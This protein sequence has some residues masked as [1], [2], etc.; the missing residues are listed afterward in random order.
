[1]I[2]QDIE[3][4]ITGPEI[5]E[6]EIKAIWDEQSGAEITTKN[7]SS[8]KVD[9]P[10]GF[11]GMGIRLCPDELLLSSAG[12]CLLLTFLHLAKRFK[13]R[14]HLLQVSLK[15]VTRFIG[16]E[17]YRITQIEGNLRIRVKEKYK[18][19]AET[20][21]TLTKK[22]CPILKLLDKGPTIII[23]TEIEIIK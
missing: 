7:G 19:L 11:G 10:V 8:L 6:Y 21:T 18:D 3:E 13:L 4:R 23:N 17:G 1:M 12:G 5:I 16:P 9:L 22:L 15:G 2:T 20:C 14:V